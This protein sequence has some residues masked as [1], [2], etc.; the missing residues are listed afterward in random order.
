M[1]PATAT[2]SISKTAARTR[3]FRIGSIVPLSADGAELFCRAVEAACELGFEVTMLAE[4]DQGGQR[5]CFELAEK[6]S[7][8]FSLRESVAENRDAILSQSDVALFVTKPTSQQIRAAI[9]AGCVPVVPEG[10]VLQNFDTQAET[11]EAFTFVQ[12]NV[13][14]LVAALVRASENRK[15]SWDWK[16]LQKNLA[17]AQV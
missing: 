10:G 6:Y 15:F 9:N 3:T 8:N 2:A 14:S 1:T 13:W 16:T 17:A 7:K 4:G 11:G 12:G 5:H